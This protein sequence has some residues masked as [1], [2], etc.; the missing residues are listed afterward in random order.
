MTRD[1]T[2][3]T[4]ERRFR[5]S[6]GA[7]AQPVER[8]AAWLIDGA[9]FWVVWVAGMILLVETGELGDPPRWVAPRALM[10]LVVVWVLSRCY[11]A[12]SVARWGSTAGRRVLGIEVRDHR[13]ALPARSAA[14]ARSIARTASVLALGAGL[15]P[16]WTD[17]RRCAWHDRV[18]RTMVV[19]TGALEPVDDGPG[20]MDDE[21]APVEP[22]EAAIRAARTDAAT[23]GWLRAVAEQTVTR[24]D[25]AAP[26]WRRGDDP[27]TTA[28]R[29]FCLLLAALTVSYPDHRTVLHRVLGQHAV[30]DDVTGGRE[31]YL[32]GL[33]S[34]H[35]RARAWLGLP[36]TASVDILVDAP[37][38]PRADA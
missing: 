18:A 3:T 23:A 26:S 33:L 22:T 13:G 16:L 35:D 28:Q 8:M 19:R 29:A 4:A 10:W 30:L 1:P 5:W 38:H 6:A 27:A 2:V 31:R 17:P 21:A 20:G 11:D 25:V 32:A 36:D 7:I 14:F 9:I 12:L 34:D 37:A 24:L 15:V